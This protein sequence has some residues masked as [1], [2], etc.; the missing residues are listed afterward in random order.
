MNADLSK[1]LMSKFNVKR[2]PSFFVFPRDNKTGTPF[3]MNMDGTSTD[4]VEHV[5]KYMLVNT[6]RM[7]HDLLV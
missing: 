7:M 2:L 4:T 3:Q 6:P 5:V 1:D